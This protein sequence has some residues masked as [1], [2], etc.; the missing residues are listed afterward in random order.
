MTCQKAGRGSIMHKKLLLRAQFAVSCV[1]VAFLALTLV[2]APAAAQSSSQFC[3]SGPGIPSMTLIN[4]FC[5]S[6]TFATKPACPHEFGPV[7]FGPNTFACVGFS[8]AGAASQSINTTTRA[9]TDQA[10]LSTLASVRARLEEESCPAGTRRVNGV[11]QPISGGRAIGFAAEE[12]YA[13]DLRPGRML[14][15]TAPT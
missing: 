15:K 5:V 14:V 10:T 9:T 11:C 2:P 6:S 8:S 12:A 7:S 1:A 13:A 3:P 4:G